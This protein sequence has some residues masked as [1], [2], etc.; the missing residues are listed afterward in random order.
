M[1]WNNY[2]VS[3]VGTHLTTS[4]DHFQG[5]K[6]VHEQRRI[7]LLLPLGDKRLPEPTAK[8]QWL[9]FRRNNV[10]VWNTTTFST[11]VGPMES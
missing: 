9:T 5:Q 1:Y 10:H 8:R 2:V 7:L 11:I 4:N 6:N 3:I